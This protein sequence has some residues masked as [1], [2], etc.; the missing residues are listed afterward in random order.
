MRVFLLLQLVAVPLAER[1]GHGLLDVD[2]DGWSFLKCDTKADLDDQDF[3]ECLSLLNF[4]KVTLDQF[5][6]QGMGAGGPPR[7]G[8]TTKP[9]RTIG[10]CMGSEKPSQ[11]HFGSRTVVVTR[12][13]KGI[14]CQ[15]YQVPRKPTPLWTECSFID[16]I[17]G[18][19]ESQD[20]TDGE[21]QD[22]G[23]FLFVRYG[24]EE[25]P[26]C[27]DQT[28]RNQFPKYYIQC[29][30]ALGF[31]PFQAQDSKNCKVKTE[32]R[33]KHGA[34]TPAACLMTSHEPTVVVGLSTEMQFT[35]GFYPEECLDTF[36]QS[37]VDATSADIKTLL[38]T[39][40]WIHKT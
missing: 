29:L 30:E 38:W 3:L 40:S 12:K 6:P 20:P 34:F 25:I 2:F 17:G 22:W 10:E 35:C 1:P 7:C 5:D 32:L 37:E 21:S 14:Q 26:A 9:V 13:D 28:V 39:R 11:S 33:N 8:A 27:R 36:T 23:K 24:H 15:E 4:R 19:G 18:D 31:V 16:L